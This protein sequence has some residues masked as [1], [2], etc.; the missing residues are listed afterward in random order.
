MPHSTDPEKAARQLANLRPGQG[1]WKP[2]ASPQLRHGLRTRRPPVE[3]VEPELAAVLADLQHKVP[4]PLTDAD[5][6]VLPWAQ[7]SV[8]T[9]GVLKHGIVRCQRFLAQRGET[10]ERGRFRPENEQLGKAVDRYRRAL[11][12]EAMTLRSRLRAGL[13][14]T[15]AFDL[16]R[17]W[18]N[19]DQGSA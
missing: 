8:W 2:G 13:D 16:A 1:R 10:D 7:E 3:E 14:V 18:A 9:L 4:Q 17:H 19:E 12:A 15:R 11:D 6:S 5:W